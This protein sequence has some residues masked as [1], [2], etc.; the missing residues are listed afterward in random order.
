MTL[1]FFLL[2]LEQLTWCH[3]FGQ[4]YLADVQYLVC[5]DLPSVREAG[6]TV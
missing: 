3:I 1:L 2:H 4:Y 5:V 6:M